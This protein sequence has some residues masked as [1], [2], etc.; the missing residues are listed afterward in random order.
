MS[1]YPE[2]AGDADESSLPIR[3]KSSEGVPSWF[4]LTSTEAASRSCTCWCLEMR[5]LDVTAQAGSCS[6]LCRIQISSGL[7]HRSSQAAD[8]GGRMI[9][10]SHPNEA[11]E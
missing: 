4:M 8:G 11:A 7:E 10:A 9:L 5:S 1:E 2:A 6:Q 3:F